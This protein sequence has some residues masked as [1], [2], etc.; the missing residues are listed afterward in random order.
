MNASLEKDFEYYLQNQDQLVHK[1][2]GRFVVI[3]DA[4]VI[5]V[6]ESELEGL[7]DASQKFPL[8][9]FLIQ[10]CEPGTENYTQT[11]HSQILP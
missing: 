2:G 4:E 5:G 10:K 11:F 6:Y 1:Y 3:K 9:T 8:G 7:R